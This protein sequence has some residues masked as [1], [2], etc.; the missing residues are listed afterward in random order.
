EVSAADVTAELETIIQREE[1]LAPKEGKDV[2]VENN[3]W[4]LINYE[5]TLEGAEFTDSTGSDMQ[6]KIGTP[7]L[8]EFH[9]CLLGMSSGDEKEEELE[10]P[11][12]FGE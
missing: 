5:G 3:D 6:F 1:V 10:L 9:D 7:D 2:K 4:V 12:R 8:A 11:E